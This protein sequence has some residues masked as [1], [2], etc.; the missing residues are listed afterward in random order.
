MFEDLTWAFLS[1]CS[2]SSTEAARYAR[3][4]FLPSDSLVTAVASL[5]IRRAR[6]LFLIRHGIE[7]DS[8]SITSIH[9]VSSF[10]SYGNVP[11]SLCW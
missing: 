3:I 5:G 9:M 7:H 1:L 11:Q 8:V 6:A 10:L 2:M 4:Q